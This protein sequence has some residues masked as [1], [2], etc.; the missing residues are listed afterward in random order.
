MKRSAILL[1]LLVFAAVPTFAHIGSPDVFLEGNAGPYRL[2]VTVRVPQVIPGIAQVEVRSESPDVTAIRLTPMQLTGPGSQFAP[3]PDLGQRSASDPQF[4]TGSLWLMEFGSLQV[5]IQ[6]DGA[7]GSGE[8]AVPVPAVA[9]GTLPMRRPL[10]IFLFTLMLVLA[11]AMAS[12]VSAAVR[13]GDL[14]PGTLA[15]SGNVRRSRVAIVIAGL[16]IVALL[17][18]GRQWWQAS[19]DHY[20]G[21]IYN[22]P[23]LRAEL[24]PDGRLI[25][26]QLPASVAS[27]N[28]RA[29]AEPINFN[30]LLL[31]HEHLMHFFM[32]RT[33]QMDSFWH[34]HPERIS[35]DEFALQLPSVPPG[36]YQLYADVVLNSG[37]PVTLIGSVDIPERGSAA[38]L[39]GDDSE[40]LAK[41]LQA[42]TADAT[43]VSALADGGR[44]VWQ[45]DSHSFKAGQ[46]FMFRFLAENADGTPAHNLEPYMGMAAHAEIIRSDGSVFAHIHPD[47]TV[48]MP[49]LELAQ[50]G[51]AGPSGGA[52]P[53][54][55]PGMNMAGMNMPNMKMPNMK[56]PGQPIDPEISF[57]YGFPKPGL[58]R[59]FVQVKRA[60]QVQTAVFDA[61]VS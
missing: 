58:Y 53:V 31:D 47:G 1:V 28:P 54:N 5:R 60:G 11:L 44:M 40:V 42:A 25:L 18:I 45:R 33:P 23:E 17:F 10:G 56:M 2:F 49:A 9:Q 37:F 50:A 22:A 16:V 46:P 32:I 12:I 7:R 13:E 4:F 38:Q 43:S 51:I 30:H 20:A 41:P 26:H 3:T 14:A 35:S 21:N 24:T 27:G 6:A 34:L 39:A 61:S 48:A 52:M 36:H 8:M 19:A 29:P 57:P 55:M 59:V 15:P